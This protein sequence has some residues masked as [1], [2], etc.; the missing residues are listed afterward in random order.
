M[1]WSVQVGSLDL[2]SAVRRA[3]IV[4][5]GIVPPLPPQPTTHTHIGVMTHP[6]S[7][8]RRR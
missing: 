4:S 3:S 6:I 7:R 8:F 5:N 2:H 1:T